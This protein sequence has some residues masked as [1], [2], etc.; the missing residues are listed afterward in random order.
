V[1][2]LVQGDITEQRVDAIVNAANPALAHGG[3]V[4]AA[5]ARAAG[6]DLVRE[7]EAHAPVAVGAA[8]VTTAGELPARWVIHAVGPVWNGGGEGEPG[9]L[10][11]AYRS[12]LAEAGRLGAASIAFPSISTGIYGYP[13]EAAAEVAVAALTAGAREPDAP[14]AIRICLFSAADLAAYERALATAGGG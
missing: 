9:L 8:G 14:A 3:G 1:I 11:S 6:P 2:E 12:A 7:S 5:I 10:D 4:A 13:I